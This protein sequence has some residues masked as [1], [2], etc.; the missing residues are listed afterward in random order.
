MWK[1]KKEQSLNFFFFLIKLIE[2]TNKNLTFNVLGVKLFF[3][4]F[5]VKTAEQRFRN[6]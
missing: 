3:F 6:S 2:I 4:F 5:L 1:K